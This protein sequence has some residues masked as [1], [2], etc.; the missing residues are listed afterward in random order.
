MR[1]LHNVEQSPATKPEA[2]QFR[3]PVFK[4]KVIFVKITHLL[5]LLVLLLLLLSSFCTLL[6]VVNIILGVIC[7]SQ[8]TTAATNLHVFATSHFQLLLVFVESDY[9]SCLLITN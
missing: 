1:V 5:L 3:F 2:V 8:G 6:D 9:N 4:A 7:L